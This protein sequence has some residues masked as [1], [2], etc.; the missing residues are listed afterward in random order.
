MD[1]MALPDLPDDTA[2]QAF[3][4]A[5]ELGAVPRVQRLT[6]VEVTE[7]GAALRDWL[8]S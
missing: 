2:A 6:Y 8:A 5:L 1:L 7:E 4:D 3:V